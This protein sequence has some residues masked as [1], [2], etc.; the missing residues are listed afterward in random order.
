M[1]SLLVSII[2]PTYNLDYIIRETLD[3]VFEQTYSNWECII[4]D[5]GSDDNTEN[6]V[7][8]YT[9]KDSRFQ[10]YKRP[11][12]KLK[13]ANACR[14]YGVDKSKGE[15]LIFLD[16]DDV[17]EKNCL[18]NRCHTVLQNKTKTDI[19][20]FSMGLLVNNKK[21]ESIFNKDFIDNENYL[22]Q[23]LKGNACWQTSSVFWEREIF[24][25]VGKFDEQFQ[26]L[27]D[28]DLHTRLLLNGKKIHRIHQVD[29]WYRNMYE[30]KDYLS[31]ERL[32]IIIKAHIR[33]IDKYWSFSTYNTNI[34]QLQLRY[35]LKDLYYYVLKKYVFKNKQVCF[36]EILEL[37]TK[38]DIIKTNRLCYIKLLALYHKL[39]LNNKKGIGYFN[40]REKAFN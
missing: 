1:S 39:G 26:R 6:V 35:Y 34:D 27:Q 16:S 19:F 7:K 17:L 22:K 24:K 40:I 32:P 20:V 21:T 9:Q 25:A 4:V 18:E 8:G 12:N 2:I 14:N 5:D 13:G 30:N 3:S 23:F 10:Y 37:N 28:V 33:Y 31:K 36:K 29:T 11:N 15:Y 38:N